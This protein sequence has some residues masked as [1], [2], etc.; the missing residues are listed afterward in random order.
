MGSVD[1]APVA[2]PAATA[3]WRQL[4]RYHWFVLVVA[5]LAWLFDT[6]DQQI[7]A[8]ARMPA[9]AELKGLDPS[10]PGVKTGAGVATMIFMIGWATG[11]I[12]F[13]VM[14][15]RVG[16]AR[17]MLV[18]IVAYSVFTGLSALSRGF[19]DFVLYRFLTGLGVGGEFA[20]GVALVAETMPEGARAHALSLLQASS[21]V[22]NMLAAGIT[23]VTGQLKSAGMIQNS[24]RSMFLVGVLPA[25]LTVFIMKRLK[26]PERWQA[27]AAH[28]GAEEKFGSL[29][30]PFGDRRWL[31]LVLASL[32]ELFG[33]RRWRRRAIVGLLLASSG[34]I[35]LWGIAFFV[36]DLIRLVLGEQLKEQGVPA[37]QI[38]G[39]L[40]Q[41]TGIAGLCLNLGGFV[42]AYSFSRVAARTGRRGAFALSFLVALVGTASTFWFFS[43]PSDLYWMMPILGFSVFTLF[44][45]YAVYFPE[46]FPTRLRSTGT[47]FCYNVG[48]YIAAPGSLCLGLL[49]TGL[50]GSYGSIGSYRLAGVTMCVTFLVGLAALPFAPETKGQPLPE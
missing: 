16:R 42:G 20:V 48:R 27:A 40:E 37:D 28:R 44:G 22:G 13:G 23:W 38:Q 35:G 2:A 45:G 49:A 29:S 17:T 15:D 6:M 36:F 21:A 24:W 19:W 10:E 26:E 34:V 43:R 50:Y 30:E 4:T 32:S 39:A 7:F 12:I 1:T 11:G 8:L 41:W 25:F 33:D 5:M 47:S 46:L 9:V 14:G 18:T 3:W 31:R